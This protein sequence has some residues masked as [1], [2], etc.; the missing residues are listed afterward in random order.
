MLD[1]LALECHAIVTL[2]V[3]NKTR[4]KE[5]KMTDLIEKIESLK[6]KYDFVGVRRSDEDNETCETRSTV[7]EDGEK[8]EENLPGLSVINVTCDGWLK[9]IESYHYKYTY[10]VAGDMAENG[11]DYNEII[12]TPEYVELIN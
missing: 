7:W 2:V 3:I 11:N 12:I 10:V 8:T 5:E 4:A 9:S 6:E 1:T